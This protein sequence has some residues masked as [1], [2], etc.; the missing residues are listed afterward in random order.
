MNIVL[1]DSNGI[2]LKTR[3]KYCDEDIHISA[4]ESLVRAT[5]DA[6]ASADDIRV[7]QS[8]YINEGKVEGTITDY[9]GSY[10]SNVSNGLII[11]PI[12]YI[13]KYDADNNLQK[14]S[15]IFYNTPFVSQLE[16]YSAPLIF[17]TDS[18]A[19]ET[20]VP[21][22][23][24]YSKYLSADWSYM[25][26]NN[27]TITRLPPIVI[28]TMVYSTGTA[29]A[30]HNVNYMFYNCTNLEEV[31]IKFMFQ[32]GGYSI[33]NL[34][35]SYA[36]Q[37]SGIKTLNLSVPKRLPVTYI[38]QG[39][40]KL[41]TVNVVN[42]LD[43]TEGIVMY[44]SQTSNVNFFS[45]CTNIQ[46][47]KFKSLALNIQLGSGTSYGHLLT[48]ESLLSAIQACK[49]STTAYTLTVGT[50]NTTKLADVYVKIT[51]ELD[52]VYYPFEVCESTDEGAMDINTYLSLKN[53]KLA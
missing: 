15:H 24:G 48:V 27:T 21:N 19:N 34:G 14:R 17:G 46:N 7:G 29:Y 47:V 50:A 10:E 28:K 35:A 25:F 51:D 37:Y 18:L 40:S 12:H 41:E 30:L 52:T 32:D 26:S 3:G 31:T 49:N 36:L 2:T 39:A 38:C 53:W 23:N 13:L 1:K 45:G 9:D 20:Y 33:L 6:T 42:Y 5:T 8:A 43:N 4:E 22:S 16:N 44:Y 11:D